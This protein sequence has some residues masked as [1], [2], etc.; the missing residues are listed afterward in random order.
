MTGAKCDLHSCEDELLVV[1]KKAQE[2]Y[3]IENDGDTDLYLY[4][5]FGRD[6]Y[7]DMDTPAMGHSAD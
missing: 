4:K 3:W 2:G 5:Y 6:I 1:C 7:T